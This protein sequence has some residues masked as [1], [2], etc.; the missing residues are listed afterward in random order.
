MKGIVISTKDEVSVQEFAEPLYQSL[1]AA[2]GG[3]I[4]HVRP[5]RLQAPYCMI[6]NEEGLLLGLPE[7]NVGS[8]LYG[9][10]R[11]GNTIVGNIVIMKDGYNADGEPDIVGLDENESANLLDAFT[12]KARLIRD[13]ILSDISDMEEDDPD[14][15][16]D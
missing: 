7:N 14:A 13:Y 10:D 11:H 15:E 1:N 4:E 8:Y 6:A 9:A 3:Y 5:M 2:V 12:E 16:G